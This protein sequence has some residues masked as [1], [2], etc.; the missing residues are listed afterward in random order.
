MKFE[1]FDEKYIEIID[2]E[3]AAKSG[4]DKILIMSG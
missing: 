4:Y 3:T 2:R 1:I